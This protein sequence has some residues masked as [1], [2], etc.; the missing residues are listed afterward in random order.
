MA[1]LFDADALKSDVTQETEV[2]LDRI[3]LEDGTTP[4]LTLKVN[5]E[6]RKKERAAMKKAVGISIRQKGKGAKSTQEFIPKNEREKYVSDMIDAS[7]INSFGL[8]EQHTNA[9]LKKACERN[10][11]FAGYLADEIADVFAG[12]VKLKEEEDEENEKN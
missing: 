1:F 11:E 4:T 7:V 3:E 12:S 5:D 10:P 8:F 9:L 6:T 2:Q